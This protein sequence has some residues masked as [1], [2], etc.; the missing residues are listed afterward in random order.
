MGY[1][2]K[3]ADDLLTDFKR[4]SYIPAS[5]GNYDDPQ[6]LAVADKVILKTVVPLLKSLD[7]GWY[8]GFTDIALSTTTD[9]YALPRYAMFGALRRVALV[10]ASTGEEVAELGLFSTGDQQLYR[11]AS[12]GTP[13]C[14]ELNHNLMRLNRTPAASDVSNYLMRV[15]YW[16]RPGRLVKVANAAVVLSFNAGAGAGTVTYTGAPPTGFTTTSLHDFYSATYPFRREGQNLAATNL[17][18]AVQTFSP[19]IVAGLVVNGLV[20]ADYACL[21]DETVFPDVPIELFPFLSDLMELQLSRAK[22]DAAAIADAYKATLDDMRNA[23]A[24]GPGER[25]QGKRRKMSLLNSGL[26]MAGRRRFLVND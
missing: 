8:N 17:A 10:K 15:W 23:V 14:F 7:S 19:T 1:Q 11:S 20:A 5:Q 3:T 2:L 21:E 4:D 6:L 22:K 12:S 13:D 16:R 26:I 25:V 9:S 24:S 18:G